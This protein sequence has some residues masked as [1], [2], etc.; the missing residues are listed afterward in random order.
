M[1]AFRLTSLAG[2]ILMAQSG[3]VVMSLARLHEKQ[4]RRAEADRMV[5][6]TYVSFTQGK[7][8]ADLQ[9]AAAWIRRR[10]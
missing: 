3:K 4:G 10:R 9:E 2:A 1:S 6:D 5:E 8:T 7:D